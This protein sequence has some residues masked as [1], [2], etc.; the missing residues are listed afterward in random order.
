ML[1][2][3]PKCLLPGAQGT[4]LLSATVESLVQGEGAGMPAG[5]IAER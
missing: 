2:G 4:A 5:R 3:G 1:L